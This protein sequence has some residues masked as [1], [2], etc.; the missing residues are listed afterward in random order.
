VDTRPWT[1][2]RPLVGGRIPA[3]VRTSVDLPAPLAP[4]TPRTEPR[5]TSNETFL[6][7]LI[8]RTIFSRRP[9]RSRVVLSVGVFSSAVR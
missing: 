8:S 9:M 5:G 7:A 4:T 1:S 3:I 6:T 2:T